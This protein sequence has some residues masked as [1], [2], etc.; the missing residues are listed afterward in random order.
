MGV[1]FSLLL[2]PLLIGTILHF[3]RRHVDQ[4]ASL[5]ESWKAQMEGLGLKVHVNGE[6]HLT[7]QGS[8]EGIQVQAELKLEQ[9]NKQNVLKSTLTV[10]SEGIPRNLEVR[11]G[12]LLR[13]AGRLVAGTDD[14]VLGDPD[15]DQ[16]V[17]LSALDAY[18]CAALSQRARARMLTLLPW[19]G[20][21]QQGQVRCQTNWAREQQQQQGPSLEVLH[22]A[23]ALAQLLSVPPDALH[24]RLAQN[25][26]EDAE[27]AVR[28]QNL[29]FLVAAETH[30]PPELLAST[31]RALLRDVYSVRLLAAQQLGV[32]GHAALRGLAADGNARLDQRQAA[33]HSLGQGA[34]PDLAGLHALLDSPPSP[35]LLLAALAAVP[36]TG[37]PLVDSVLGCTQSSYEAVRVAAAQA[38]GVLAQPQTEPALLRL[39][40][41]DSAEVQQASAEALG[42][43]G[44]VAA[45]HPLLP[46]A[47]SLLR[48]QLRQAARGAIGR[49]QSRLGTVEAGRV[50][51][52]EPH[53]LAG[54]VD[55]ADAPAAVRAGELSLLEQ[56]TSEQEESGQAGGD[57]GSPLHAPS[58]R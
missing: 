40:A 9:E 54:A 8:L 16:K 52:A 39:L 11:T 10:G 46:L 50:S 51:L 34:T 12:S 19:Q 1:I 30:T 28:L 14:L 35:E 53:E 7:A 31:A 21:I 3:V 20:R 47:D 49:I 2:I 56:E 13:S 33:V 17:Q 4:M 24:Q 45:V 37:A 58:Q 36:T 38:L 32:Q 26:L 43:L 48:P 18:T 15:F 57:G 6:Y 41:D 29:R 5:R 22:S 44:S 42:A 27:P 25:A 23:V 55:L